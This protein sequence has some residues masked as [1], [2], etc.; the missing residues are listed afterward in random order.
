MDNRKWY[1]DLK[2]PF[3]EYVEEASS[4]PKVKSMKDVDFQDM[5]NP[6]MALYETGSEVEVIVYDMDQPRCRLVYGDL[7][8]ARQDIHKHGRIRQILPGADDIEIS[9]AFIHV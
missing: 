5:R 6:W 9:Q 8:N 3:R 7:L 2:S 1:Q 4:T